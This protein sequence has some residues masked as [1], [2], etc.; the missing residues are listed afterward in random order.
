MRNDQLSLTQELVSNADAFVE[1]AA[2]I[3]PQIE[4]QSLQVAHLIERVGNFVL[5]GFVE[6]GDVHVADA[7]A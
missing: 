7:R 4:D 6:A 3:L 5:R 1:Q 2:G